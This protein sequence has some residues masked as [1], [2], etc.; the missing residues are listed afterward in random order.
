MVKSFCVKERKQTE[1]VPSSEHSVKTKNGRTMM[2]CKC[3]SCGIKK[4]KFVKNKGN[5]LSP[6]T[7]GLIRA[8]LIFYLYH[9]LKCHSVCASRRRTKSASTARLQNAKSKWSFSFSKRKSVHY[10]AVAQKYKR[11]KKLQIGAPPAAV[12]SQLWFRVRVL[13]PL[14]QSLAFRLLFHS[15]A[16][17]EHLLQLLRGW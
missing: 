7:L 5:W 3:A 6:H 1:C 13:P 2:V 10:R 15:E 11:A 14:C 8:K 12:F 9:D 17:V 4:T 16:S